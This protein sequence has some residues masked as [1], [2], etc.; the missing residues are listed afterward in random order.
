MSR[1]LDREEEKPDSAGLLDGL[2]RSGADK[3]PRK[4][5]GDDGPKGFGENRRERIRHRDLEY[6]LRPSAMAAMED[7]GRFRVI[8]ASD[9]IASVYDLQVGE[10]LADVRSL[11]EQNLLSSVSFRGANGEQRL[12]YTLTEAGHDFVRSRSAHPDQVYWSGIVKPAEL[13][14][15]ALLYRAFVYERSRIREEGGTVKRI[16]LDYELK[17]RHFS[18]VNKSERGEAYREAQAESARELHLPVIDG[19]VTFPDFR[20]EY[21]DERGLGGSV[22]VEVATG[23]YRGK[24]LAAKAS[25]GF[26]VYGDSTIAK[27]SIDG[28]KRLAGHNIRHERTMVLSL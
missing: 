11:R 22:D 12:V 24:H 18:R 28:G 15:D 16:V 19:H 14:H 10:A 21:E 17:G 26:R 25:A 7:V 9:L 6:M 20:V 27:L 2:S 4:D 5:E 8:D 23:N 13:E 1:W 3:R